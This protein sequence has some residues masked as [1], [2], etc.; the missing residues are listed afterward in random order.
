MCSANV[1]DTPEINLMS[2][3]DVFLR[4]FDAF[5]IC[6]REYTL[7]V[8]VQDVLSVT[9]KYPQYLHKLSVWKYEEF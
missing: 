9:S 8:K 4:I 7:C 3:V 6:Q 5:S 1:S 2:T